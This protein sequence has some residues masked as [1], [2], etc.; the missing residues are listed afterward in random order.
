M[1]KQLGVFTRQFRL[2]KLSELVSARPASTSAEFYLIRYEIRIEYFPRRGNDPKAFGGLLIHQLWS[3]K[4]LILTMKN[5]GK[6]YMKKCGN[7]ASIRVFLSMLSS[8][9]QNI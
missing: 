1:M 7:P 3:W 9:C 2:F 5:P 8:M 6:T 4:I